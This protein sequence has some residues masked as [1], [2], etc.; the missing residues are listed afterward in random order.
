MVREGEVEGRGV[1]QKRK[2]KHVKLIYTFEAGGL[3]SVWLG[4]GAG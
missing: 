4:E 2:A 1:S 3:L